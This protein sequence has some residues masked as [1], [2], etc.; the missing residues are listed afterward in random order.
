MCDEYGDD[1]VIE[2]FK[3]KSGRDWKDGPFILIQQDNL[4]AQ[5]EDNIKKLAF[6]RMLLS[7]THRQTVLTVKPLLTIR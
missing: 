3:C 2:D 4:K 1:G 6:V 5:N 7:T